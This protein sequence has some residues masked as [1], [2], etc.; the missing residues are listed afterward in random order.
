MANNIPSQ[1]FRLPTMKLT[2]STGSP[3]NALYV[4]QDGQVLFKVETQ[5]AWKSST[6]ISKVS[7]S[8]PNDE[9]GSRKQGGLVDVDIRGGLVHVADIEHSVSSSTI[10][11]FGGKEIDAKNYFRKETWGAY[12]R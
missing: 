6:Q 12:G 7:R 8:L 5:T 3:L 10:L 9:G 4:A 11:R 2:L 1:T